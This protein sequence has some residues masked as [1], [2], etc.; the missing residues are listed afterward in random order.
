VVVALTFPR[1]S[2]TIQMPIPGLDTL[3]LNEGIVPEPMPGK[4]RLVLWLPRGR[5][6]GFVLW[7]RIGNVANMPIHCANGLCA[8]GATAVPVRQRIQGWLGKLW[9]RFRKTTGENTWV[10]PNGGAG[11]QCGQRQAGL[12]LVWADNSASLDE[13]QIRSRWPHSQ[14]VERIGRNLFVV[15]GIEAVKNAPGQ[16]APTEQALLETNLRETAERRLAAARQSGDRH[17]ET[18]ALTDLGIVYTR[19]GDAQRAMA[20]LREA[21]TLAHQSG[22]RYRE[23]DVLGN[24]ALAVQAAGQ[25]ALARELLEQR[26]ALARDAGDQ[27]AQKKA[28]ESLGLVHAS[29]GDSIGALA[30][31]EAGLALA[32]SVGDRQHEADL[33][34]YMAIQHAEEGQRDQAIAEAEA[35]IDM[36]RTMANPQGDWLAED[37]QTYRTGDPG[38][39]LSAPSAPGAFFGG[40]VVA[41]GWSAAVDPSLQQ[42]AKGPGL[43][44]MAISSAK[45]MAKFLASGLKTVAPEIHQQRLET[46]AACEHH[47]GLRC[48]LCGCFTNTKSWLPY[49][50][51]PIGKWP[52]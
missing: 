28:L 46:C 27:F 42:V 32:R 38:S 36:L 33:L 35:A 3:A 50:R 19:V 25:P 41:G 2:K 52:A 30:S 40:A 1:V 11:Q 29:T 9:N 15:G 24:L 31:Y 4:N 37:L 12:I 44:R 18:T 8:T 14:R 6:G 5:V 7:E 45:S 10:L 13:A 23:G 20:V 49:E 17:Q 34:W 26:L 43:L 39:R 22:D 21:L 51:C 47:T 48:K 16:E